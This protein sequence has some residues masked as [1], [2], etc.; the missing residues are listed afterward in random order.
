MATETR[1]ELLGR[2]R[3]LQV[4]LDE[5]EETLSALRHGEVDAIVASGP[6]GDQVYTLQGADE[7]YRVMVE[8]M[9]E[10]A[11][12]VAADGLILFS[13]QRFASMLRR[14][15]ERIIGARIQDFVA[16]QDV[17]LVSA[18][19]TT[20]DRGKAELRLGT[21]VA[22]GGA[23]YL[24]VKALV[25]NGVACHCVIATD[26]SDQKR[27]A[28]MAAIME[29]V[30][31][32]VVIAQDGECLSVRGNRMA[33]EQLRIPEGSEI[34]SAARTKNWRALKDGRD[35]LE[36]EL[37]MQTVARTGRPVRD[38]EFDVLFDDGASRS[39]L[40]SAAPVFDEMGQCHGAVGAFVDITERK[41]TEE[42]L[43]AANLELRNFGNALTHDLCEPLS[44]VVK[45]T[46]LLARGSSGIPGEAAEQDISDALGSALRIEA[47][48]QSLMQYWSVPERSALHRTPVDCNRVLS[49]TLL[50]LQSAIRKSGATVTYGNLP[51]VVAD[52]DLLYRL[53][54]ALVGNSIQY[55][56][57]AAPTIEVSAVNAADRQLFTVRD[58][59]I[60]IARAD[61]DQVFGMFKRLHGNEIPGAG[62]GLALCRKIVERHGGRIWVESEKGR[63]AAFR[64]TIPSSFEFAL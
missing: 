11:L 37:P 60:G 28:E 36:R 1:E 55:R 19:L 2:I 23:V 47:L 56:G 25:L 44:S 29:A 34:P 27:Y 61:A 20:P 30:P 4:R 62:V 45:F 12:T 57:E 5:A 3:D 52:A 49:R 24:S 22:G 18:L 17:H 58:N 38:F 51:T 15:L 46:R 33:H 48:L 32:G 42:A 39:W 35:I 59:G 26:L 13:N 40:A 64:F 63:G 7:A 16:S 50:S 10:G 21:D 9:G 6:Q 41:Q 8:E 53:F 31:V 14:P 43:E 54:L